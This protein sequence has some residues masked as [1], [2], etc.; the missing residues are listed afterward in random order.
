MP[1]PNDFLVKREQKAAEA[2]P[3]D[4]AAFAWFGP[5]DAADQRHR[6]LVVREEGDTL[7][8]VPGGDAKFK[9]GLRAWRWKS[10]K[11][12]DAS[13]VPVSYLVIK[14]TARRVDL[15]KLAK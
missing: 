1:Q 7:S 4:G 6:F 14:T 8:V 15:T 11:S 3:A 13:E 5:V 10:G 2:H 12:E 9:S